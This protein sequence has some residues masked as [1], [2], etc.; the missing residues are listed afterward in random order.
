MKKFVLFILA[1][2]PILL[3]VA[4]P[5]DVVYAESAVYYRITE[6]TTLYRTSEL[7]ENEAF[8]TLPTTY[9]VKFLKDVNSEV[10]Q[11][12]YLD[13]EGFV[14]K[15]NFTRV[16]STPQKPYLDSVSFEPES[17]ANL[18]VRQK[19]STSSNFVGTIPFNALSVTY[20]GS[21][22]GEQVNS[23][24]NNIWYF[25][26]YTSP[27]QGTI[28]GY[29]YSPL[30]KNLTQIVPNIEEV[31]LSPVQP[32][33][34]ELTISPELQSSN[35]LIF[36]A[37]LTILG[38]IILYLIFHSHNKLNKSLKKQLK[39]SKLMLKSNNDELDF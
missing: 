32:A 2:L 12:E 27:E 20:L 5:I 11:V 39:N 34:G 8:F 16:Y 1:V 36:I 38:M 31:S 3:C 17:V 28:S 19:P 35:N 29:V 15:K 9:F 13:F 14:L 25:C 30:T 24:L 22:E 21:I 4:T 37:G 10:M 6:S 7:D 23:Q 26:R 18:V 33:S